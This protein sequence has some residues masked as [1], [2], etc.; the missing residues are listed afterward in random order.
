MNITFCLFFLY[1]MPVALTLYGGTKWN[2][3]LFYKI[4]GEKKYVPYYI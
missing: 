2:G 3:M 1:Y 4:L